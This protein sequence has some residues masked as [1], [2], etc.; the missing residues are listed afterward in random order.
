M[1]VCL[2]LASEEGQLAFLPVGEE[3]YDLCFR[4]DQAADPR[5]AALVRTVRSPEYRRLLGEL[6][7]YQPHAHLG[8][9]ENVV[10]HD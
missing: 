1:G 9:L 2:R 5:M 10:P 6:P 4:S 8:E 7:G 3:A